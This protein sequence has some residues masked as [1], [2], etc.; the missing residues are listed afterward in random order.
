MNRF[1]VGMVVLGSIA[2]AGPITYTET[3]T[4]TGTIGNQ[5]FT[6]ALLTFNFTGDTS[7]V[8]GAAP[9]FVISATGAT[10]NIA[11]IGTA[12]IT[13]S[14]I[15]VFVNETFSPPAAG[16]GGGAGS[17]LDTFDTAFAPYALTTAIGPITG[18]SF[19]RSDLTFATTLGGL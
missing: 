3:A 10:V 16:F 7:N 8:T 5:V 15:E 12:T 6:S 14:G 11:G 13:D 18:T 2:A 19:I 9:F 1:I 4:A 17:I